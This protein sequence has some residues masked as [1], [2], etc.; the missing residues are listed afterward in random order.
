SVSQPPPQSVVSRSIELAA[1]VNLHQAVGPG[2]SETTL[3]GRTVSQPAIHRLNR[4]NLLFCGK[5][6]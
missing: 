2:S 1:E 6:N 3:P 4:L 5:Q